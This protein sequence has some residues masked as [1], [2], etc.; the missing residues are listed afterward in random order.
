MRNILYSVEVSSN[1]IEACQLDVKVY[2]KAIEI[3]FNVPTD[4]YFIC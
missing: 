1:L 3:P 4:K 2:N